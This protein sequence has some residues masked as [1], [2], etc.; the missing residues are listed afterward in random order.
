MSNLAL[1]LIEKNTKTQNPILDLGNCNLKSLPPEVLQ[2]DWL[3]SLNLSGVWNTYRWSEEGMLKEEKTSTNKGRANHLSQIPNLAPLKRLRKLILNETFIL[4]LGFLKGLDNLEC[5]DISATDVSDLG[6]LKS[7]KNLKCLIFSDCEALTDLESLSGHVQLEVLVADNTAVMDLSPLSSCISLKYLDLSGTTTVSDLTPLSGLKH[8]NKLRLISTGVS[9]I[10]QLAEMKSMSD[11]SLS[12]TAVSNINT[13]KFLTTL[14]TLDLSGTQIEDFGSLAFLSNLNTLNLANTKIMILAPLGQLTNLTDLDL[15]HN[16][17]IHDLSP[18]EALVNLRIIKLNISNVND[19]SILGRLPNLEKLTLN[20]KKPKGL[21]SLIP[22]IQ[23]IIHSAP[24]QFPSIT[25][26]LSAEKCIGGEKEGDDELMNNYF[27]KL[28]KTV[29]RPGMEAKVLIVGEPQTGKTTLF[30]L[31]FPA[32]QDEKIIRAENLHCAFDKDSFFKLNLF[33]FEYP[34][35][36]FISVLYQAFHSH[37]GFCVLLLRE[38]G[39]NPNSFAY[40]RQL[41]YDFD[42]NSPI[43]ILENRSK[44]DSGSRIRV[45][46]PKFSM[47]P[48]FNFAINLSDSKSAAD[49]KNVFELCVKHL[50]I[51]RKEIPLVW[52][53]VRKQLAANGRPYI[54]IDE[55]NEL[56]KHPINGAALPNNDGAEKET[57]QIH[58]NEAKECLKYLNDIG[59]FYHPNEPGLRNYVIT[60]LNWLANEVITILKETKANGGYWEYHHEGEINFGELLN[61]LKV[62]YPIGSSNDSKIYVNPILLP[63]YDER[64]QDIFDNCKN[65]TTLLIEFEYLSKGHFYKYIADNIQ[66]IA[67]KDNKKL[68]YRNG[69]VLQNEYFRAHVISFLGEHQNVIRISICQKNK[70]TL[71]YLLRYIDEIIEG[72]CRTEDKELDPIIK[73][74][75]ICPVCSSSSQTNKHHYEYFTLKN[76][77]GSNR[78]KIQCYISG[79][80]LE[81]ENLLATTVLGEKTL[82]KEIL[83]LPLE[84]FVVYSKKDKAHL[85]EFKKHIKLISNNIV[86]WDD[87]KI[88]PGEEWDEEITKILTSARITFFLISADMFSTEYVWEKEIPT[89]LARHEK[90]ESLII[91]ILIHKCKWESHE[92][93]KCQGLPRKSNR[94]LYIGNM[95]SKR[96][97]NKLW[98][99]VVTEIDQLVAKFNLQ[100][101]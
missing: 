20:S 47:L 67:T 92:L 99:E 100:D 44:L 87:S 52:D 90:R 62:Y 71:D 55:F 76:L 75:C 59:V 33:D 15:N 23:R 28:F 43:L 82:P 24:E 68:L 95:T 63:M 64:H 18:L 51:L 7:L 53:N 45:Q 19:I 22:F 38:Q 41:Y 57:S 9:D 93:S 26:Y 16:E 12:N 34:D 27:G 65:S 50:P 14:R 54:N 86:L 97:R 6:G 29:K 80:L 74:S 101:R 4:D 84:A 72:L 88:L 46:A 11:L 3:E 32:E 66:K 13:L 73:I 96:E 89:A 69:A 1:E 39:E 58:K 60:D 91:P 42:K 5:L 36:E 94:D 17:L 77:L 79:D 78:H 49:L 25:Q 37:D 35:P 98:T 30:K 40:W 85:D 70:V 31:F 83:N 81:I 56:F 21:E 8:L 2:C 10:S 61:H 48:Q